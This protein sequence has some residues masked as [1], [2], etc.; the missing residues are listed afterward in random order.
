MKTAMECKTDAYFHCFFFLFTEMELFKREK[1]FVNNLRCAYSDIH[2]S[3]FFA[4]FALDFTEFRTTQ[5]E[6]EKERIR[7][8]ILHF[9]LH[10]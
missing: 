3:L 5:R 2:F 10:K 4:A 1:C 7:H 9:S 6:R 8:K